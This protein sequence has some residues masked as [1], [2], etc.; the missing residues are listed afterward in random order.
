MSYDFFKPA[1]GRKYIV[2]SELLGYYR[3]AFTTTVYAFLSPELPSAAWDFFLPA[4][5]PDPSNTLP[6][7]A[8][9]GFLDYY[10]LAKL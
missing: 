2:T 6:N 9:L 7:R 10:C 3:P 1:G 8:A 5:C 4:F